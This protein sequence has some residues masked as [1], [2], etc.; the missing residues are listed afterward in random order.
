MAAP[1]TLTEQ[2][3]S[4]YST[5]WQSMM[6]KAQDNIFNTRPFWFWLNSKGR[7]TPQ[8]GGR[9][10]GVQLMYSKNDTFK[11]IGRFAT[12]SINPQDPLTTAIANWKYF[13]VSVTRDWVG[14]QQNRGQ[15]EIIN[16]AAS[17]LDQALLTAV[18]SMGTQA[19]GDGTGNGGLDLDGLQAAV[20]STPAV[21]TYQGIDPATATWWRNISSVASGAADT[22][23]LKDL[24]KLYRDVSQGVDFPSLLL[25]T[26]AV[27]ELYEAELVEFLRIQDRKMADAGFE[28]FMFKGTPITWDPITASGNVY[29]LNDKYMKLY[30]D[31]DAEFTMTDWK[32][33]PNQVGDRVAQIVFAGNLVTMQRRR[34]GV[35]TGVA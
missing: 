19:F 15:Y 10:I 5:T 13:A 23:L 30:Y 26:D 34:L 3:D 6:K 8:R 1:A 22:F 28:N 16:R 12:V 4:F 31:P 29:A 32:P 33:I 2:L 24:R 18:E 25:T 17:L 35:L 20:D 7:R 21:G 27:F 14:D 11:S 9:F